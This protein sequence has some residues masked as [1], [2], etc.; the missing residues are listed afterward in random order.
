MA[1]KGLQFWDRV[2]GWKRRAEARATLEHVAGYLRPGSRVLDIGCGTGYVLDVVAR[3]FGCEAYGC[4][5]VRQPV[6]IPNFSLF[7]GFRLPYRD[8]SVDVAF[9]VFVLHHAEDPGVLLREASRV[10]RESVIVIEDT[11]RTAIERRWGRM[12]VHSF[13]VRHK[14]PW[15]GRVRSA[16]EWRQVF[17]FTHTPITHE[18]PLGRFERLPPV[19]R[20]A[21]VLRAAP[22]AGAQA[23]RAATS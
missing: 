3:D 12:H 7:D 1:K 8:K 17:Q 10:A 5:V 2:F 14:I 16:E 4:D 6:P 20:A 13:G 18:E 11:P 23:V 9:L 19:S 22:V 15:D 21:F